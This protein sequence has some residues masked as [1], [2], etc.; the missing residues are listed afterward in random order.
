MSEVGPCLTF[1]ATSDWTHCPGRNLAVDRRRPRH[2]AGPGRLTHRKPANP[3]R[4]PPPSPRHGP[5]PRRLLAPPR[6]SPPA[7]PY[8]QGIQGL[9][10]SQAAANA[11]RTLRSR[12][13]LVVGAGGE[14]HRADLDR[15]TVEPGIREQVGQLDRAFS[16][17][18]ID[19]VIPTHEVLGRGPEETART[20]LR[21]RT[22]VLVEGSASVWVC[23]S[24]HHV[25]HEHACVTATPRSPR[26]QGPIVVE[27]RPRCRVG[28][29]VGVRSPAARRSPRARASCWRT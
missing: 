4:P 16:G 6:R 1:S 21:L 28:G 3:S 29:V 17:L 19:Q 25:P 12:R 22:T 8:L 9:A 20:P 27:P 26:Q 11:A 5:Q 7:S 13:H 23:P 24:A 18:D 15:E 14:H 2:L 10:K